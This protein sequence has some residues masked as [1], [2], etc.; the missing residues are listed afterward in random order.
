M[1]KE[2]EQREVLFANNFTGVYVGSE[3][4][5]DYCKIPTVE[6]GVEIRWN[7]AIETASNNA[8]RAALKRAYE[9]STGSKPKCEGFVTTLSIRISAPKEGKHFTEKIPSINLPQGAKVLADQAKPGDEYT[10]I[11][12]RVNWTARWICLPIGG[13]EG[14]PKDGVTPSTGVTFLGI[15]ALDLGCPHP[16]KDGIVIFERTEAHNPLKRSPQLENWKMSYRSFEDQVKNTVIQTT[17]RELEQAILQLA[18]CPPECKVGDLS[19]TLGYPEPF[20]FE[21]TE[22]VTMIDKDEYQTIDGTFQAV[23]T[24]VEQVTYKAIGKWSWS[25][26]RTCGG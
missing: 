11:V 1:E 18:K 13:I 4:V 10:I 5:E 19:I 2:S 23:K 20:S 17:F 3:S 26:Q 6:K 22:V 9:A 24:K 25:V 7:A 21:Y 15:N 16:S 14:L 12:M 8:T